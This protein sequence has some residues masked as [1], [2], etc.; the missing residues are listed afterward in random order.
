VLSDL[1]R[2]WF[3]EKSSCNDLSDSS[4]EAASGLG[5]ANVYAVFIM[6]AVGIGL[7]L[8]WALVEIAYYKYAYAR[9]QKLKKQQPVKRALS[10]L[11]SGQLRCGPPRRRRCLA[12]RPA[13]RAGGARSP[14]RRS[15]RWHVPLSSRRGSSPPP[16][17]LPATR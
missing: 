8:I 11:K 9:V 6:L 4:Q 7:A 16:P 14:G 17:Q 5:P 13:G 2:K 1:R 15:S 10:R 12:V 3:I